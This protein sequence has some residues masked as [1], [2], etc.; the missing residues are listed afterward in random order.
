VFDWLRMLYARMNYVVRHKD[1]VT[2]AFK[3]STVGLLTGDPI[4]PILWDIFFADLGSTEGMSADDDL[5]LAGRAISH[6]EQADDV[7]LWAT[8]LM[9]LQEKL[10]AFFLWCRRNFVT[11]SVSKTKWMMFGPMPEI[12]A[13]Q[14]PQLF[15]DGA[16]IM[17]TVE[18]KFV[19]IVFTSCERDI[20]RK[21]YE[22]MALKA[23]S[24][25]SLT[26][27]VSVHIGVLPVREGLRMYRAQVD[28]YFILGCEVAL[29]VSRQSL[30]LLECVQLSF[31]R[32]LL[33]LTARCSTAVLFTET[34]VLP[35]QYRRLL[36]ALRFFRYLV[37]LPLN[38]FAA[39]ASMDSF[40]LH[41]A[42]LSSWSMDIR[43]VLENLPV[44]IYVSWSLT[45][46]SAEDWHDSVVS[47]VIVSCKKA[48]WGEVAASRKL[49]LMTL[50]LRRRLR[51]LRGPA[52]E[53]GVA[54]YLHVPTSAHRVALTRLMCSD[55]SF[56]VEFLR[57]PV[58]QRAR[59][60]PRHWRLC[61][62]GCAQVEDERHAILDC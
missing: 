50:M 4:S 34:G 10:S 12:S 56:A 54:P 7:A 22:R 5:R 15:V 29:D 43:Y 37:K 33:G 21:H 9:R 6:V 26:F 35:L 24:V 17:F 13:S 49:S 59:V 57:R 42:A 45:A 2:S 58:T 61:R 40:L 30:R 23:S 1:E 44:P 20:F 19:G 60:I 55:H 31:L 27:A 39:S 8:S 47:R 51:M 32:R 41:A 3:Q 28:P 14:I 18:Y 38:H 11:I 46:L 62:Y 36:V 16:L 53:L 48:L 25:T 52:H